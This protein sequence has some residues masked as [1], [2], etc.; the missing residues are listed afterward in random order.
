ML[1]F[2][3]VFTFCCCCCCYTQSVYAQFFFFTKRKI[4]I[5]FAKLFFFHRFRSFNNV[6]I[7]S[8][9]LLCI[10]TKINKL[11]FCLFFSEIYFIIEFGASNFMFVFT[12]CGTVHWPTSKTQQHFFCLLILSNNHF[13][14]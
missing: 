10:L 9:L 12:Y 4:T 6:K 11:L 7:F 14:I 8:H 2:N 1:L 3:F 13:C 5:A